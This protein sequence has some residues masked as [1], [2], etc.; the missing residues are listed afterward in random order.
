MSFWERTFLG[1]T[2]QNWLTALLV[3]V[4]VLVAL[5]VLQS[6]LAR[7]LYRFTRRTQTDI[8][9]WVGELAIKTRFLPMVALSLYLGSRVLTLPEQVATW[10]WTV[11]MITLLIQVAIWVDALVYFWLNRYQKQY[12]EDDAARATT[13]R[14]T[15]IVVRITLFS[16]FVLLALDNIPGVQVTTLVTS[17]G[18]GGVAVALAVQSILADLFA[19]L[20]IALDRPF[21]IDDFI[22]VGEF[23]GTVEHIG[24]KTTRVRSLSG[25]QLVFSNSDLLSSRIRNYKRMEDRRVTFT[26][27]VA[28]ETEY[29]KLKRIPDIVREIIESHEQTRFDRAHFKAYGDFSLDFEVVYYMLNPDFGLY[30]DI[31]Q[32]INLS[33]LRRFAEEGI[34]LPYPTQT[35]YVNRR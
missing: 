2:L 26:V 35:L 12:L 27:G 8:D 3:T 17:L 21:V 24:L 34:E 16:I 13:V 28:C 29:E 14:A 22:T 30:M 4:G 10:I 32:A 23:M 19:S 15:T 9:D 7:R 5:R 25:E 11:A 6:V 33:L 18:I 1:N 20:T 31:Q